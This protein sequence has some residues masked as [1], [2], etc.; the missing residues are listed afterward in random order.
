VRF[1]LKC[2]RTDKLAGPILVNLDRVLWI[3][4]SSTR[5]GCSV[6]ALETDDDDGL[7]EVFFNGRPEDV[8]AHVISVIGV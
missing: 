5:R 6:V 1:F 4:R 2:Y 3:E 8:A 7:S